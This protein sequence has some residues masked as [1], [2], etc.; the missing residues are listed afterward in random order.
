MPDSSP[1]LSLTPEERT[2]QSL[3]RIQTRE[4]DLTRWADGRNLDREWNSRAHFVADLIDPP[5]RVIDLGCGA[6]ALEKELRP[7]VVYIPA[8]LVA[9]DDRTHVFDANG[10]EIP[11]V[12]ADVAVALRLLEYVHEPAGLFRKCVE[13]WPRLIATYH[14]VDVPGANRNRL[15]KGWING[16]KLLELADLAHQAGYEPRA[17]YPFKGT[18]RVFD[19]RQVR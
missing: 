9:R 7:G 19:F 18:N 5:A 6:M 17:I 3:A 15:S 13:R 1:Y 12:E 11:D 8:D 10:G 14:P 16:L 2:Q 4:S